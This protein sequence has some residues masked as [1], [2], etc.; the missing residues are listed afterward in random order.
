MLCL[1]KFSWFFGTLILFS[2][3]LTAQTRESQDDAYLKVVIQRADKIVA[4]LNISDSARYKQV[5]ELI[6][7]Q[8]F[9]LN[10]VQTQHDNQVKEIKNDAAADKAAAD[11]RLKTVENETN[12]RLDDLHKKYLAALG[13][14]LTPEQVT[15]V[16]DGMTYSVLPITYKGYMTM[17]PSLTGPQKDQI[18]AWLVEAREHA[19]DA[20]SS[21]AKHAWFGKY[22]GRINNYLSAQGINMKQAS[23]EYGKKIKEDAAAKKQ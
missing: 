4:T 11:E 23:E 7:H 12:V 13:A 8:Y 19:M 17:L 16:K 5:R 6:A 15:Q 18:M 20:G 21:E 3:S 9:S 14:S 2:L 22:K 1:K 10:E